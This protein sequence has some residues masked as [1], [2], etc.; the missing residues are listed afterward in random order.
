MWRHE[1]RSQRCRRLPPP[2]IR[3]NPA[4]PDGRHRC[5]CPSGRQRQP[6]ISL[7]CKDTL[8]CRSRCPLG[9]NRRFEVG[10]MEVRP[11]ERALRALMGN[12][13][14]CWPPGVN[15]ALQALQSGYGDW[16]IAMYRTARMQERWQA[17]ASE[18]HKLPRKTPALRGRSPHGTPPRWTL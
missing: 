17:M 18:R 8:P 7:F 11:L 6:R 3:T 4:V 2:G 15:P 12:R 10:G 9:K 1:R 13:A 5:D 16:P 14:G